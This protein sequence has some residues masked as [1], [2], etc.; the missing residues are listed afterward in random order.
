MEASRIHQISGITR[1]KIFQVAEA[2]YRQLDPDQEIELISRVW[3]IDTIPSWD[4]R[5]PTFTGDLYQHRANNLDWQDDWI[6]SD[7]RFN[8]RGCD[9]DTLLAFLA[10]LV[11]PE[12][13]IDQGSQEMA[14]E[15]FNVFLRPDGFQL[16]IVDHISGHPIYEGRPLGGFQRDSGSRVK[17]K[18]ALL[19]NPNVLHDH[20]KV[21]ERNIGSDPA[22]AIASSKE[23]V[24]TTM[25]VILDRSVVAHKNGD[26]LPTLYKKVADLLELQAKAVPESA[27]A[28]ATTKRILGNLV[29]TVQSLAE[30]RNE[31]GRGHGRN[32]LSPAYER[33]ARLAL[34]ASVT[35][36]EF[37]I[38][39]WRHRVDTGKLTLPEV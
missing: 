22:Q 37:L 17:E 2:Y 36:T 5:Y 8:L 18:F 12:L 9:D 31:I 34:N 7:D 1:R 14:V 30:L 38:E 16:S 23:L 4:T 24:E 13:M 19:G 21:I 3:D 39:T 32:R 20:F 26:D 28:S 10:A 15:Q 25:R 11:Y 6:F 27:L 33:H 29:A 35:V